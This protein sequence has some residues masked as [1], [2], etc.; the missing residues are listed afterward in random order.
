MDSLSTLRQLRIPGDRLKTVPA[1]QE[2]KAEREQV[3][4]TPESKS[5]LIAM[6][7]IWMESLHSALSRSP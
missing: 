6:Q 5:Y 4:S 3:W 7:V 2:Q 1:G